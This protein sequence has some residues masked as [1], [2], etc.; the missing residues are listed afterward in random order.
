MPYLASLQEDEQR[1]NMLGWAVPFRGS[2]VSL[3]PTKEDKEDGGKDCMKG[4]RN[5]GGE[6]VIRM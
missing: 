2:G 1:L 5:G 3:I 6:T 4:P